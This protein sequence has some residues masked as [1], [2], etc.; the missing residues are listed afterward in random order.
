MEVRGDRLFVV[1]LERDQVFAGQHARVIAPARVA[2]RPLDEGRNGV[3]DEARTPLEPSPVDLR[4]PGPTPGLTDGDQ[5]L[6]RPRV[7]LVDEQPARDR[8]RTTGQPAVRRGGPVPLEQPVHLGDGRR[9]PGS[10]RVPAAG[11]ED[12]EVEDVAQQ[13][14]AVV[15]QQQQP[16]FDSRGN[17]RRE[18]SRTRNQVEV[19][20]VEVFD[21]RSS[22]RRPL[23]REDDRPPVVAPGE[24]GRHLTT[25]SVEMR[26]DHVQHEPGHHCGVERVP[27][28]LQHR[29]RG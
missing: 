1:R 23:T 28:P 19:E 4:L 27:A 8:N 29:H 7:G 20:R 25:G 14:G 2:V 26:L 13:P 6:Q 11:V 21:R 9:S 18:Q 3:G 16:C 24:D 15:A 10:Q 12:R 5:P 17:G 22:R